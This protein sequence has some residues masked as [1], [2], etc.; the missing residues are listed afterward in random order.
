MSNQLIE[1]FKQFD[2]Y[3]KT[4]EDFRV[5]TASGAASNYNSLLL[6]KTW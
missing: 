1:K 3:A 2:A 4:L 5:R 6:P